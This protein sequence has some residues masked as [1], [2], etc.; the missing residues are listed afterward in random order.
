MTVDRARQACIVGIGETAYSRWGGIQDRSQ[1]E[2]TGEAIL[3]ALRDAS[4]APAEVD[5]FA[6]FSDDANEAGLMQVALGV[7]QMR[8]ASMLWGG[9][10]GGSCGSVSLAAAAV[11]SGQANV[12]VVYRGL[13][14]GQSGRF[15]RGAFDFIHK[16]FIHPFGMFAPSQMLALQMRRYM[17]LYGATSDH[18]AEVALSTRANA[19]RNPR[20]YMYDRPL[21]RADYDASPMVSDPFRL[22]DCCLESDGAAAVVVTTRERARDM[23]ARRVDILASAHGSGPGWGSGPLGSHNMPDEDY[24]STNGR[25]LAAELYAAAGVGPDNVDV[26]QIYDH[27]SGIVL[28]ALEDYGFCGRGEAPGFLDDGGIRWPDGR[29]P[30]NTHGG[31]LSEAYM[32]GMTHIAEGVR[33]IR[34]DSTAQ[35]DGA[36]VCLVTGGLSTSPTSALLL[37]SPA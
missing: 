34:G 17:H 10:G 37:G 15:G 22:F 5:G 6:S 1:F 27:F 12:V 32:H 8:W 21:T 7:P 30:V 11:E 28:M 36:E 24:A 23:G 33:Q 25:R 26:A 16:N 19:N 18:L 3:A 35:V 13:C 31:N 4:L 9:G 14:Q 20:A 2:V 29:L